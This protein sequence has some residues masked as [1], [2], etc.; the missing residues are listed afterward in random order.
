MRQCAVTDRTVRDRQN[1]RSRDRR[2]PPA[3]RGATFTRPPKRAAST[4]SSG[5][6]MQRHCTHV[7]AGSTLPTWPSTL[8]GGLGWNLG[9]QDRALC[10]AAE[11]RSSASRRGVAC[12]C[13]RCA[14]CDD[15]ALACVEGPAQGAASIGA[16]RARVDRAKVLAQCCS[17]LGQKFAGER[18]EAEAEAVRSEPPRKLA[19]DRR[20]NAAQAPLRTAAHAPL[21]EHARD[22]LED[23]RDR[24]RKLAPRRRDRR[25][26]S[27]EQ[28][29][30][31]RDRRG[32]RSGTRGACRDGKRSGEGC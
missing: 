12:A 20:T 19:R 5:K 24:L 18:R 29:P 2:A 3:A 31:R 15:R 9:I 22:V 32:E 4:L 23:L 14:R 16:L 13:R 6:P 7:L 28:L 25:G 27:L 30:P 21:S 26:D 8:P 17:T 11:R 1:K 10:R